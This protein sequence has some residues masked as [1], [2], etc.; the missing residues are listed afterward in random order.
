MA[1]AE[2]PRWR[3]I[4]AAIE[5]LHAAKEEIASTGHEWGGHKKEAV[6]AIDHAI[7]HLEILRDWHESVETRNESLRSVVSREAERDWYRSESLC[8]PETRSAA[9]RGQPNTRANRIS[10]TKPCGGRL[11]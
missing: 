1:H 6:E 4:H 10:K 11:Q 9:C 5:A 3:R 8:Y 7:H 2:E